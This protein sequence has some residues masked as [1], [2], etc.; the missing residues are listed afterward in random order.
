MLH[1]RPCYLRKEDHKYVDE[2]TGEEMATSVTG[3]ID[4][5]KPPY[6]GPENAA[7]R[8]THAHRCLEALVKGQPLP[9]HISPEGVDCLPWFKQLSGMSFWEKIELLASE[10]TMI[11]RRKSLGGQADLI[12]KYKGKTLLID[13]KTKSLN[14]KGA[15]K[16]E[17]AK[18]KAQAGG[19]SYLLD[20]GDHAHGGCWVDQCRTLVVTPTFIKWL[21]PMDPQACSDAWADCWDRYSAYVHANPF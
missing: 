20:A 7:W 2:E 10:Y 18:Y 13:L 15:S 16:A 19:Y 6:A 3:V 4:H 14:W 17:I 21:P 1:R 12:C 5:Q 8:G 11:H 9:D